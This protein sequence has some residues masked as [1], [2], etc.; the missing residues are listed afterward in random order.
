MLLALD[1]GNTNTVVGV[2][3]GER[4][5]DHFRLSTQRERTADE[6]GLHIQLALLHRRI[7]P[8]AVDAVA[9]SSV[10]P[11]LHRALEAMGKSYFGVAPF[12]VGPGVK[13]GM[14]ILYDDPREVGADRIVNAV[15]AYHR[16]PG[17]LI[18]VD[19]GTAT[20]LEVISREG[21]YLG[22]VIA[23]GVE[24]SVAAL[25]QRASRL[26]RVDLA[27]PRSVL[28]RNTVASMRAGI[29][30]GYAAMVDGLCSRIE[31]ELGEPV[32]RVVAT[33]G[34]ARLLAEVSERISEV[35]EFL[36][37]EGL[38]LIWERNR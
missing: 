37:L 29:V 31:R 22:G 17:S 6:W 14:R 7:E 11:P 9:V 23:P 1:V 36:T 12:F 32:D 15:A 10:V 25:S 21:E 28:G 34:L 38:R 24:I 30:H 20:T 26:P 2:F 19:F 13:T 5:L 16:W 3:E 18:V 33:G 4:L 8:S 35:D 27:P